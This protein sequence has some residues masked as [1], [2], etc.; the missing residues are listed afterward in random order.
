MFEPQI[1][2]PNLNEIM[3]EYAENE[4]EATLECQAIVV[5]EE[6]PEERVETEQLPV[7]KRKRKRNTKEEKIEQEEE[8]SDNELVSNGAYVVMKET[9]MQKDFVGERGFVKLISPF[10]EV[11]EKRGWSLLCE[12]KPTRFDA[13]VREFYANMVGKKEKTFMSKENG[14]PSIWRL[15]TRHST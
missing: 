6:R 5:Q 8:D 7:E 11:I 13:L 1:L 4:E 12:H 10:R 2:I 3:E 9:L 15:S 14:S